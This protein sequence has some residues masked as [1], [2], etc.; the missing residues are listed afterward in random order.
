MSASDVL[1]G[2]IFEPMRSD[3]G[4]GHFSLNVQYHEQPHGLPDSTAEHPML[5]GGA[6]PGSVSGYGETDQPGL[7]A[8]QG[9][10]GA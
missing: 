7:G 8:D 3:D 4:D 5:E 10:P 6:N 2:Q 9:S 1:P